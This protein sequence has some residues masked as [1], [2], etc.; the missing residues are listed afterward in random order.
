MSEKK[1]L[2]LKKKKVQ[3]LKQ[4]RLR[5]E[6]QTQLDNAVYAFM[7]AVESCEKVVEKEAED[8]LIEQLF[9]QEMYDK[10]EKAIGAERKT[11]K[12]LI[13]SS[14]EIAKRTVELS[15]ADGKNVVSQ[16]HLLKAIKSLQAEIWP[17]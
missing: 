15:S 10:C 3:D 4:R 14:R 13:N 12:D 8:Y 6:I 9:S 7:Y 16:T 17:F 11:L 1:G 5:R 2:K